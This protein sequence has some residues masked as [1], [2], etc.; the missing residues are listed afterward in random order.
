[1]YRLVPLILGIALMPG[2]PPKY[3]LMDYFV[4]VL[5]LLFVI[6]PL[7]GFVIMMIVGGVHDT[8]GA[9]S[10]FLGGGYGNGGRR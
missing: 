5:W 4:S 3:D 10:R 7:A 2:D 9:I 1:M 8:L 6:V